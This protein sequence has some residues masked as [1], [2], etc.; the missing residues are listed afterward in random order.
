MTNYNI[1]RSAEWKARRALEKRGYLVLRSAG[2]RGPFDLVALHPDGV[3]CV[4]VKRKSELSLTEQE[5]LV[6]ALKH[7]PE[8]AHAE[9][10]KLRPGGTWEIAEF[11]LGLGRPQTRAKTSAKRPSQGH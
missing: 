5:K 3:L 9:V 1:G 11:G 7:L 10:W 8:C 6:E 4:Q 2:S